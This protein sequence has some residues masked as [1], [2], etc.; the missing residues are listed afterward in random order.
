MRLKAAL[1]SM[2][3]RTRGT[4]GT[5]QP[6]RVEPALLEQWALF[7]LE[8]YASSA[9]NLRRVLQ[10]RVWRR[11][12]SDTEAVR[13]AG[14][15]IDALVARYRAAGLVDDAAYAAGRARRGLS[16]GRSLRQIAAGLIA[17]GI[18]AEDAAAAV[19]AL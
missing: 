10:R 18:G 16:R 5:V 11:L 9:E 2:R 17:K 12:G 19:A 14:G 3:H 15:L 13:A 6:E 8:R 1:R 4:E 7:Y